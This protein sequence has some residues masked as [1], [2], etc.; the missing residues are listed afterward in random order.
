METVRACRHAIKTFTVDVL[1]AGSQNA[2][3]ATANKNRFDVLDRL[4][5]LKSG[6]SAG[7]RNDWAWFKDAWDDKMVAEHR[8]TWADVFSGWMR[9]VL[10]DDHSNAFSVFV[11]NETRRVLGSSAALQVPGI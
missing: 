3:G 4:S 10:N 5:R 8:D 6:L 1:G 9:S 2:G 11:Y 7:Q